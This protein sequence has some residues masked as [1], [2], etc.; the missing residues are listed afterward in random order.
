MQ[1]PFVMSFGDGIAAET[2]SQDRRDESDESDPRISSSHV[3]HVSLLQE[4]PAQLL[5]RPHRGFRA[6]VVAKLI[7]AGILCRRRS[8]IADASRDRGAQRRCSKHDPDS[9][10]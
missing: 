2:G 3:G 9:S 7:A 6:A 4:K 10:P 5:A 1:T 8:H